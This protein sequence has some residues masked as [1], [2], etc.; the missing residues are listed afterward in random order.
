MENVLVIHAFPYSPSR[1]QSSDSPV[2]NISKQ[3]WMQR[4]TRHLH[5]FLLCILEAHI[6]DDQTWLSTWLSSLP[7][8]H[9]SQGVLLSRFSTPLVEKT[10]QVAPIVLMSREAPDTHLTCPGCC[11]LPALAS[12]QENRLCLSCPSCYIQLNYAEQSQAAQTLFFCSFNFL[13]LNRWKTAFNVTNFIF[14][15]RNVTDSLLYQ[16]EEVYK[17]LEVAYQIQTGLWTQK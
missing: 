2:H 12:W 6:Q 15:A 14:S 16:K 13:F 8:P 4:K 7:G 11:Q 3:M 10:V 5:T 17:L 9:W 1:Q